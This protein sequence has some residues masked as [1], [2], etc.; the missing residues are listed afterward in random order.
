MPLIRLLASVDASRG[1]FLQIGH[2]VKDAV[3]WATV[4]R[5]KKRPTIF[6]SEAEVDVGRIWHGRCPA[7]RSCHVRV[8][9]A[10]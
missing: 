10:W 3:A 1:G 6:G 8:R 2:V 9:A 4:M 5:L 7:N